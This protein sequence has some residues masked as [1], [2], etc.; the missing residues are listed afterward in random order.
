MSSLLQHKIVA[1]IPRLA[2]QVKLAGMAVEEYIVQMLGE[3]DAQLFLGPNSRDKFVALRVE[4]VDGRGA[5]FLWSQQTADSCI[6]PPL[7][8]DVAYATGI[9]T[10]RQGV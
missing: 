3:F 6:P 9:R 10:L 8:L 1:R 7:V 4:D 2:N 5:A